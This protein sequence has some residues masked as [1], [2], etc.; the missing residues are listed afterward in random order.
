MDLFEDYQ[1]TTPVNQQKYQRIVCCLIHLLIARC[2]IQLAVIMAATHNADPTQG[3]LVKLIRILAYLKCTPDLDPTIYTTGGA[4]L[5]AKCDT[6]FCVHPKTG[7]SQFFDSFSIG[8]TSAPFHTI[9]KVQS[10]KISGPL[11]R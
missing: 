7:G 8:K 5:H 11:P 1:D 3:D 4:I 6:A 2:E 9:T 10:T